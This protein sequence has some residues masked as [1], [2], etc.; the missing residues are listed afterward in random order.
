MIT[1]MTPVREMPSTTRLTPTFTPPNTK[2][3]APKGAPALQQRQGFSSNELERL[4][5]QVTGSDHTPVQVL[6]PPFRLDRIFIRTM[7]IE[8]NGQ[9]YFGPEDIHNSSFDDNKI[10]DASDKIRVVFYKVQSYCQ[11][12]FDSEWLD[13]LSESDRTQLDESELEVL[14]EFIAEIEKD[15]D[16]LEVL[17]DQYK[18]FFDNLV[19]FMDVLYKR[20]K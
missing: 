10:R 20:I 2:S 17:K 6:L 4:L 18:T 8:I 15:P 13:R 12:L 19:M 14:Q 16:Q 7:P 5:K 1:T 9:T 11:K 3:I